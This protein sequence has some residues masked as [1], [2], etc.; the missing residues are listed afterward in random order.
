MGRCIPHMDIFPIFILSHLQ[1]RIIFNYL[2]TAQI[3]VQMIL[4]RSAGWGEEIK[5]SLGGDQLVR[6]SFILDQRFQKDPQKI[7][8]NWYRGRKVLIQD[9]RGVEKAPLIK[10]DSGI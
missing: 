5:E 8:S 9:E 1:M 10:I 2:P 7:L 6:T 3:I 4:A